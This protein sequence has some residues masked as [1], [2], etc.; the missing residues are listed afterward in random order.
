VAINDC[1]EG[2]D[3][4]RIDYQ[5][6]PLP[7]TLGHDTALCAGASIVLSAPHTS[8]MIQWQDGSS[9]PVIIA[10]QQQLYSLQIS[11][12]CGSA[13][14]EMQLT[15]I[16]DSFSIDLDSPIPWCP[17]R[18]LN[19]NVEQPFPATYIWNTGANTP[20]LSITSPGTYSVSIQTNCAI[21][22]GSFDVIPDDACFSKTTYFIPNIFSPNG[23]GIND[24]FTVHFNED[25]EVISITGTIYD[26]WGNMIYSSTDNSFTWNGKRN[27]DAVNPGVYV[28]SFNFTLLRNG[29]VTTEQVTGDVTLIR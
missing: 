27:G 28:Y 23:D 12:Q 14:D 15:L 7:F 29:V 13:Y 22:S 4:I 10:D 18:T 20:T 19:I 6:A 24:V 26:R 9:L 25:S 16:D 17:E 8:G 5:F 1:G 2:A 3:T 11:N 21:T